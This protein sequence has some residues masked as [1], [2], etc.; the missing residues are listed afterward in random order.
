M[1]ALAGG[2]VSGS[3]FAGTKRLGSQNSKDVEF[4][5]FIVAWDQSLGRKVQVTNCQGSVNEANKLVPE[6]VEGRVL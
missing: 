4:R 6:G 3:M 1:K 5:D 2:V